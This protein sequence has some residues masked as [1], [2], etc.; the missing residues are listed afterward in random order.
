MPL[1]RVGQ[2]TLLIPGLQEGQ[3]LAM[4]A[5]ARSWHAVACL[6]ALAGLL[7]LAAPLRGAVIYTPLPNVPVFQ[8]GL[9]PATYRLDVNMDGADDIEFFAHDDTFRITTLGNVEVIAIPATPPNLGGYVEPLVDGS[10]IGADAGS[11]GL[12]WFSGSA[13]FYSCALF[14]ESLVC[15]GCWGNGQN[16]FG[17]RT[18]EPDGF[19]YGYVSVNT[20]FLGLHGGYVEGSGYETLPDLTIGAGSIPESATGWL[21]AIGW[22]T[23][24]GKRRR[25]T[26]GTD[27]A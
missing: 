10:I 13:A 8:G 6:T 27:R 14:D 3:A 17:F 7:L 2:L 15:L 25:N 26:N 11:G 24:V 9:F 20:P 12:V 22:A 19:H 16:Y 1:R 21:V 23:L 5:G 4:V 18:A